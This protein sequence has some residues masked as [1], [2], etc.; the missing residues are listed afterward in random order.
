MTVPQC[1]N[2]KNL[3]R[4]TITHDV[5]TCKAFPEGIPDDIWDYSYDHTEAYP[6]DNG[7]RFDEVNI[8]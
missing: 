4:N 7:I 8:K 3:N 5:K 1:I 6:N 2:C